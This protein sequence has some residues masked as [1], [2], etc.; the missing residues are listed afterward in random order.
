MM[1]IVPIH[2][3]YIG[4]GVGTGSSMYDKHHMHDKHNMHDE[5]HMHDKH[6]MHDEHHMH[7]KHH[8][9]VAPSQFL[10]A[11]LFNASARNALMTSICSCL[12]ATL[13]LG[14]VF[15]ACTASHQCSAVVF[16]AE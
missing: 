14:A 7:D 1:Q 15:A 12:S 5:H 8:M 16:F 2:L 4:S 9:H 13:P 10:C 6:N 11:A 3:L